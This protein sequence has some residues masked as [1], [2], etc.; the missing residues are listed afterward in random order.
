MICSDLDGNCS[1]V[2]V[3]NNSYQS[4][5]L[6]NKANILPV[7]FEVPAKSSLGEGTDYM[8]VGGVQARYSMGPEVPELGTTEEG[9]VG[10]IRWDEAKLY[11]KTDTGWKAIPFMHSFDNGKNSKTKNWRPFETAAQQPVDIT[12]YNVGDI[13][14]NMDGGSRTLGWRLI[15]EDAQ[16]GGATKWVLIE[17]LIRNYWN[18]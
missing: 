9:Q 18:S 11:V 1:A 13:V 7:N 12:G 16:L 10:D 14:W 5:K 4:T 17:D 15:K 3:F 6:D 2:S 8:P